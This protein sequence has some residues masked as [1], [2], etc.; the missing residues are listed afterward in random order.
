LRGLNIKSETLK[1]ITRWGFR[2][3]VELAVGEKANSVSGG[4]ALKNSFAL[5]VPRD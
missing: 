2:P 1:L 4:E 5:A 3:G